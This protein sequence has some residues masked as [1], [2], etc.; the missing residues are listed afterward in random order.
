MSVRRL[1]E[2]EI[3][4]RLSENGFIETIR[5]FALPERRLAYETA[6]AKSTDRTGT[7]QVRAGAHEIR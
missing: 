4:I 3:L 2:K 6:D 1:L 5:Y 7:L